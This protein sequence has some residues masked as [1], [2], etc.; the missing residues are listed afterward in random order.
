LDIGCGWGQFLWWLRERGYAAAEG[1]DVGD[2]QVKQCHSL[3]LRARRVEDSAAFLKENAASF[4]VITMH[5]VI[6][7]MEAAVGLELLRAIYG[8][9]REGGRVIL[10]TPNMNAT[11][12]NY[13]RYIEMTHV[14]GYT[15]S[16]LAE[17]LQMAG[18]R[19]VRVYGNK[20]RFGLS[21]RRLLWLGL[22]AVSRFWWRVMLTA[23]LG[24]EAP[25]VLSKNLY[26]VGNRP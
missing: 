11:S 15:D 22:Q 16:S 3:G 4:D 1:I 24:S 20:T 7:H 25:R 12:A 6:E 17:I 2:E 23:E 14:T 8:A 5:H 10:Q 18:F 9:L 19:D 26:A 21:P 13:T